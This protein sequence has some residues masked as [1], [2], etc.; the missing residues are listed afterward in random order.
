[1]TTIKNKQG[2][3]KKKTYKGKRKD[4]YKCQSILVDEL[5]VP[6]AQQTSV[7]YCRLMDFYCFSFG[8]FDTFLAGCG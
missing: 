1:M 5:F 7:L 2:K 4:F 3:K 8:T 6:S